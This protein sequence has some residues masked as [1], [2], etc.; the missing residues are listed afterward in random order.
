MW[1]GIKVVGVLL[2]LVFISAGNCSELYVYVFGVYENVSRGMF[3]VCFYLK[4]YMVHFESLHDFVFQCFANCVPQKKV[5]PE[6]ASKGDLGSDSQLKMEAIQPNISK[7]TIIVYNL[8]VWNAHHHL[9]YMHVSLLPVLNKLPF[10]SILHSP[11]QTNTRVT[12]YMLSSGVKSKGTNTSMTCL[13][14]R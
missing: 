2:P 13:L 6:S 12:L 9:I 3:F 7:W 4:S 11:Q 1:K 10:K 8:H 5:S 14:S